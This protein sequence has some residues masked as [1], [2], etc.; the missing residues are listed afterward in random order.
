[1]IELDGVLAPGEPL[2]VHTAFRG[3]D[4]WVRPLVCYDPVSLWENDTRALPGALGRYRRRVRDFARTELAAHVL[5]HDVD[6]HGGDRHGDGSHAILA[7]AGRAGLLSDLLPWPG[8]ASRRWS[9]S[10]TTASC[11]TA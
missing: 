7:A 8:S 1:M 10:A 5:E 9:C 2:S 6:Q 11:A 3:L 4:S